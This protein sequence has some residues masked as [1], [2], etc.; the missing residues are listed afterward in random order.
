VYAS[1]SEEDQVALPGLLLDSLEQAVIAT[2]LKGNIL[3][4][5]RFAEKMY[6]WRA[7]EVLGRSVL[8]IT[9]TE[10]SAQQA[11]EILGKLMRGESW[12]GE[13]V[14]RRK[15][16]TTFPVFVTDSPVVDASGRL[17]AI[18]G[19]SHDISQRRAAEARTEML[20]AEQTHRLKNMLAVVQSLARQTARQSSSTDDFLASFSSRLSA[21]AAANDLLIERSGAATALEELAHA[22]LNSLLDGERIRLNGPRVMLQRRM[23]LPFSMLLHELYTNA[24]KYGALSSP[25]GRVEIAW[26]TEEHG[27]GNALEFEWRERNGPVVVPP[28]KKGFGTALIERAIAQELRAQISLDY[29]PEG[30]SCRVRTAL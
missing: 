9:P 6:G 20:L 27:D 21:V 2:D 1:R 12:T 10:Q 18:V 5:N 30:V 4:W 13:I 14:L 28:H 7:D 25:A 15:D 22:T 17:V 29:D 8:E 24:L 26:R 19:V 23:I 11:D 16:G 3:Y